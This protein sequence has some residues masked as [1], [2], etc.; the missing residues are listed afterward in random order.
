MTILALGL[1]N[2]CY[3]VRSNNEGSTKT[4]QVSW[5]EV[6][7]DEARKI[8]PLYDVNNQRN[9][10]ILNAIE[11]NNWSKYNEFQ[12]K[13]HPAWYEQV[14]GQ[15]VPNKM[16]YAS[17]ISSKLEA[18]KA[19][20]MENDQKAIDTWTKSL[21]QAIKDFKNA[22]GVVPY[23]AGLNHTAELANKYGVPQADLSFFNSKWNSPIVAKEGKFSE[24]A[25]YDN[26]YLA[27]NS[28]LKSHIENLVADTFQT[29]NNTLKAFINEE[30]ALNAVGT[31]TINEAEYKLA[32]EGKAEDNP[33]TAAMETAL[34]T[35]SS[36]QQDET[37]Q[38][39]LLH[40]LK[41]AFSQ[42]FKLVDELYK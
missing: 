15:Y 12:A 29:N 37:L 13:Q 17:L 35:S 4:Q 9:H 34:H 31:E 3:S 19:A 25:W 1:E 18:L 10:L 26:A 6:F 21:K 30:E 16:Y 36:N 7:A 23:V 38:N 22:P 40:N 28:E 14:D 5:K 2:S 20:E 24:N 39:I 42:S 32:E 33:L 27:E 11:T 41:F 8:N